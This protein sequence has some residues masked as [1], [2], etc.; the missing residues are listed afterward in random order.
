MRYI[1]CLSHLSR[2]H[3]VLCNCRTDEASL[4]P[5]FKRSLLGGSGRGS[6]SES[7]KTLPHISDTLGA[8]TRC[9]I[10]LLIIIPTQAS[11][12]LIFVTVEHKHSIIPSEALSTS[13]TW[14]G[15]VSVVDWRISTST[16]VCLNIFRVTLLSF[17]LRVRFDG[18]VFFSS[19]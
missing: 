12:S 3:S 1:S 16:L 19:V 6:S 10:S 4:T 15:R 8:N 2:N 14:G 17:F 5:S 9:V 18:S 7:G 13:L 11:I